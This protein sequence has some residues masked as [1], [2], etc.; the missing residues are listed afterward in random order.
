[1]PPLF[2]LFSQRT[3]VEEATPKGSEGTLKELVVPHEHTHEEEGLAP[4][5]EAL[6]PS[7]ES[8]GI[9][10]E[11]PQGKKYYKWEINFFSI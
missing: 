5:F 7:E 10:E 2:E 3:P 1:M 11:V 6:S 4:H 9:T 8:Q